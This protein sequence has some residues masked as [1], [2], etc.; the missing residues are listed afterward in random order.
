[1]GRTRPKTKKIKPLVTENSSEG[2]T[3][4]P[5]IPAL[6]EKAQTFIVQCD[7]ELASRFARRVLEH[8]PGNAEAKEML[9][10]TQLETGDIFAAKE[11]SPQLV[12]PDLGRRTERPWIPDLPITRPTTSRCPS[13]AS[14][15]RVPLPG[16]TER[17]SP[18]CAG[19]LPECGR[20]SVNPAEGQ[21]AGC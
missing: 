7:Y 11:V 15:I 16:A 8:E 4:A 3:P 2:P 12:H 13:Y 9:G 6:L 14:P 20:P 10:V 17:R 18:C 21:G 19:V 1:M 5:S